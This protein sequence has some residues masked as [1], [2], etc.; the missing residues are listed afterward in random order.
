MASIRITAIVVPMARTRR[1]QLGS[2]RGIVER[3]VEEV[4]RLAAARG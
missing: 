4:A 3:L 1:P 2:P